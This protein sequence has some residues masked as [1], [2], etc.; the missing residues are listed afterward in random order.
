MKKT[1]LK[2]T[3]LYFGISLLLMLLINRLTYEGGRFLSKG[4][5]HHN[6]SFAADSLFPFLP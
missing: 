4:S 5:I 6:L 1:R 3:L 2:D